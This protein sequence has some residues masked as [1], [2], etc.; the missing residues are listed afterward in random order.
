MLL[1]LVQ[2]ITVTF[3]VGDIYFFNYKFLDGQLQRYEDVLSFAK[4]LVRILCVLWEYLSP[5]PKRGLSS[6][7]CLGKL[8]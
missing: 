5:G 2:E 7:S 6:L 3:K 8:E 1:A 4:T